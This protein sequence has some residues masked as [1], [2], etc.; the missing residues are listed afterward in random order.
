M[1]K[2][3][4]EQFTRPGKARRCH[5]C[6]A[7]LPRKDLVAYRG[8]RPFCKTCVDLCRTPECKAQRST[9]YRIHGLC[10]ECGIV[11]KRTRAGVKRCRYCGKEL[12]RGIDRRRNCDE[13]SRRKTKEDDHKRIIERTRKRLAVKPCKICGRVGVLLLKKRYCR[14]CYRSEQVKRNRRTAKYNKARRRAELAG[15]RFEF[16]EQ[17]WRDVLE[18]FGH[19]CAYCGRCDVSMTKDHLRPIKRGGD[20]TK[21][22]IVPAC[23]QCNTRKN[24]R[25]PLNFIWQL[26]AQGGVN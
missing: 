3:N 21:E 5:K 14:D 6:S 2:P 25:M 18:I 26:A 16:S 23:H 20:H 24:A 9:A 22:N 19:R 10:R 13:C 11:E 15:V 4:P 17:A 1:A 12:P 7:L 8:S